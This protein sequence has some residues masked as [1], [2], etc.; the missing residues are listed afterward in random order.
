MRIEK[1]LSFVYSFV[2]SHLVFFVVYFPCL[3][4]RCWGC[5]RKE[6]RSAV[7]PPVVQL[8]DVVIWKTKP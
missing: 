8:G 5:L 2:L 1:L 4:F 6:C 3:F 7:I